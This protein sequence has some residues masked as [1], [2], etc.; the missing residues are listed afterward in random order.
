M[1]REYIAPFYTLLW[2]FQEENN[3]VKMGGARFCGCRIAGQYQGDYIRLDI[4]VQERTDEC[5]QMIL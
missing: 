3:L 4:K 5:S 1:I 2:S